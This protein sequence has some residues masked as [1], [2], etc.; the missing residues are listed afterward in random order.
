MNEDSDVSRFFVPYI[1]WTLAKQLDQYLFDLNISEMIAKECPSNETLRQ[2]WK[3]K[4]G[5]VVPERDSWEKFYADIGSC[6]VYRNDEVIKN[7]LNDLT[8]LPLKS[9]SIMDGGTQ[10][11]LIFTFENDQQAVF[12]PMR[13]GRDYES[14]PNHFYFS[15]FERHNAEIATF[16]MDK[17][18]GFRRAIPTVGRIVNLTSDL[19]NKAEK[20][21]AKTFFIS[22][23]MCF[24]QLILF[25]NSCKL[26]RVN[27]VDPALLQLSGKVGILVLVLHKI[28]CLGTYVHFNCNSSHLALITKAKNLCFVSKCDYYCDT[29]HAIC[30][31]PDTREGS[32]QVFLPDE[33]SVP[34]KHNKSPYRRTYSKKNQIAEWQRNMDYCRESVKTTKPYAHGRMLLDLI[35]FHVMDYLIGNQDRHHYEAFSIFVPSYAIH[36]DNGRAFGRTDFDDDDILLPLRQC[37]VLR[38]STFLTLLKY[39]REPISLTKAL[40]QSMSKDPLSP[41]LAYKHY[42]AMERKIAQ[43]DGLHR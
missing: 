34:R 23:G 25:V 29:S 9:V 19:R 4:I 15:D 7:L 8:K 14:D 24:C 36:L 35:D 27:L 37:C 3:D 16:H 38:S 17:I 26:R 39:Y 28:G 41:I 43:C 11:K 1:N 10:V 5:K 42:P 32:V 40:H 18:L 20:R 2:V 13:F 31:T 33:N 22:P 12:K 6:D 21:L 30:G